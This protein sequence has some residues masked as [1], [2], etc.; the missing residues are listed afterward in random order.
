[1]LVTIVPSELQSEEPESK[2]VFDTLSTT[3]PSGTGF[4]F[5]GAMC[6]IGEADA[7][8]NVHLQLKVDREWGTYV[9]SSNYFAFARNS[10]RDNCI[11][12]TTILR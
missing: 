12:L 6:T 9:I 5:I 1:M 10:L 2:K 11:L 4:A 3:M 7:G 8:T